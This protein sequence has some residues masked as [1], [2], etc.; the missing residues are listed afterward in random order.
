MSSALFSDME[1]TLTSG[2]APRMFVQIGRRLGIFSRWEVLR[3]VV[4]NLL[5][6]PFPKTSRIR[7]QIYYFGIHRL[8]KNHSVAEIEQISEVLAEELMG[9][10]KPGSLALIREHQQAG[11]PVIIV[12]AGGHEGIVAFAKK[13]GAVRGEGTKLEVKN[14]IYTG[15]GSGLCQGQLKAER[16]RQ[17]AQEMSISL[18]ESYGMGDTGFDSFFLQLTGHP[19]AIDPEPGLA[20]I[21][22]QREW[23]IFQNGEPANQA[24]KQENFSK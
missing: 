7:S 11:R 23:T 21:A 6:K 15:R 12:S 19:I 16:V 18:A 10:L 20:Q 13:L 5:S 1:G 14:G 9:K 24:I 3:V 4:I 22:R 8:A 2:S 17:V